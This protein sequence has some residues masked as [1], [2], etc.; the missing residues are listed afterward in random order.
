MSP[1][2]R[3]TLNPWAEIERVWSEWLVG[4]GSLSKQ[5]REEIRKHG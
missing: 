4:G 5:G 2:G 3:K 1:S